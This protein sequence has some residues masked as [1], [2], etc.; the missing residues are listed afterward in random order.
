MTWNIL[1]GLMSKEGD[2]RNDDSRRR[3]AA[4]SLVKELNPDVLVLNE[5]L[6][7]REHLGHRRD[8]AAIFGYEHQ[9]SALY[10]EEWGNAILSRHPIIDEFTMLI[11]PNGSRQN[12]G[13]LAVRVESEK[14]TLW[15]ATF[16][17]HPRR[18]AFKRAGDVDSFLEHLDGPVVLTGD[19][20]AVSPE[21]I[22]DH[23][24]LISGFERF[25]PPG[26][27]PRS[28][29][30]FLEAGR[31][32]FKEVLPRFGMTDALPMESRKHTIPTRLISQDL[33]SAIRIDHL[34][35][36]GKIKVKSARV[37]HDARADL[38]SDHYPI[39]A[40]ISIIS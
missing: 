29:G 12:R 7:C 28:V 39:I 32:L 6:N 14:E 20:N 22:V 40:D 33:S 16:H 19:M 8:Y 31:I 38:A 26:E 15:V 35:A 2:E 4:V 24:A 23:Q 34:L 21:D 13:A 11:H 3:T 1:E 5:A 10:D 17:P 18:R 9:S 30:R 27:A 25:S 36:N 37:V